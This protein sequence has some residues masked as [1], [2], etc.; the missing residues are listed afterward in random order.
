[1]SMTITV[2]TTETQQLTITQMISGFRQECGM[3]DKD[4]Q[5][6]C[7]RYATRNITTVISF[8]ADMYTL[9]YGFSKALR[10]ELRNNLAQ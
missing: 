1:M 9:P 7:V 5:R 6:F 4:W 8:F 10:A 3:D 2:E